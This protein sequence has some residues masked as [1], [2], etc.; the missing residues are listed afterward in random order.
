MVVGPLSGRKAALRIVR[1]ASR[2]DTDLRGRAD[3][4]GLRAEAQTDVVTVAYDGNATQHQGLQSEDVHHGPPAIEWRR[5][6]RTPAGPQAVVGAKIASGDALSL[7]IH[8][9]SAFA[10]GQFKRRRRNNFSALW[11]LTNLSRKGSRENTK[12]LGK[13]G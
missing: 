10:T 8:S 13:R 6:E 4:P 9:S 5:V 2:M 1:R 3:R 11:I 7:K 12:T